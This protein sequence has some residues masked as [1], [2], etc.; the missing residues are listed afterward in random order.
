[1]K[2]HKPLLVS[3][4]ALR[5]AGLPDLEPP[6]RTLPALG[7]TVIASIADSQLIG[8]PLC[9]APA[10]VTGYVTDKAKP[11]DGPVGIEAMIL[12]GNFLSQHLP[13][14]TPQGPQHAPRMVPAAL[15]YSRDPAPGTWRSLQDHAELLGLAVVSAPVARH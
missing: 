7:S 8:A 2:P 12:I 13:V 5:D 1:M 10:F 6:Q 4:D 3:A 14:H 15:V 9:H 11:D